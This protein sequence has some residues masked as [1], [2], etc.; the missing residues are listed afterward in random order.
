M[1][2]FGSAYHTTPHFT[3]AAYTSD[4]G[5]GRMDEKDLLRTSVDF[6]GEEQHDKNL[7]VKSF[8][9]QKCNRKEIWLIIS[10]VGEMT[11]PLR[12]VFLKHEEELLNL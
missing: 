7:S 2:V 8:H 1:Q 12:A 10:Q 6:A 11:I 4:G 9:L 5:A 3:I